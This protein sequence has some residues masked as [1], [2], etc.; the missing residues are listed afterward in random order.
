M[1]LGI[2]VHRKGRVILQV[3]LLTNANSLVLKN[4]R[5][6]SLLTNNLGDLCAPSVVQSTRRGAS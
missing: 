1:R 5:D 3:R 4:G 6:T 2:K